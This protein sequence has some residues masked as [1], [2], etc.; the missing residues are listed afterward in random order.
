MRSLNIR[1]DEAMK[2]YRLK[3]S[4][5]GKFNFTI[6]NH[7]KYRDKG[8]IIRNFQTNWNKLKQTINTFMINKHT[9]FIICQY[10]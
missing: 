2:I 10:Q 6:H 1:F 4:S 7:S 9:I 5:K 8:G 3:E